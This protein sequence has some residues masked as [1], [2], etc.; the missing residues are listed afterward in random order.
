MP[1]YNIDINEIKQALQYNADTGKFI[2]KQKIRPRTTSKIIGKVAGSISICHGYIEIGFLGHNYLAHRLAW[3]YTHNTWPTCQIDHINGIRTDNRIANL[4][5][6]NHSENKWNKGKDID[7]T[8]GYKGIYFDK[9]RNRWRA[10]ITRNKKDFLIGYFK[11]IEE[12][13]AKYAEYVSN[14]KDGFSRI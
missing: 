8:S 10:R 6:A 13:A 4:R 5:L 9:R 11:T 12:A 3:L 2:W 1:K 7:N 14:M